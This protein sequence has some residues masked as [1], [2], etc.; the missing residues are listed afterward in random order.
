LGGTLKVGHVEGWDYACIRVQSSLFVKRATRDAGNF[1]RS[2]RMAMRLVGQSLRVVESC[3]KKRELLQVQHLTPRDSD[4]SKKTPSIPLKHHI[5]KILCF[6]YITIPDTFYY[7]LFHHFAGSQAKSLAPSTEQSML[8]TV[9]NESH[10][11]TRLSK[12]KCEQFNVKSLWR[13]ESKESKNQSCKEQSKC[14][15]IGEFGLLVQ[16]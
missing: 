2:L 8:R 5:T 14:E 3:K 11:V 16:P 12:R 1:R 15:A 6:F 10:E 4:H 13:D 7:L 9:R